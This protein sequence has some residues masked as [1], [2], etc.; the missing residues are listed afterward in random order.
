[1]EVDQLAAPIQ[2]VAVLEVVLGS[3][4][5]FAVVHSLVVGSN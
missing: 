1:M 4:L 2:L 5:V 3:N